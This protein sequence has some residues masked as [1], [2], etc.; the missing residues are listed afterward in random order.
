MIAKTKFVALGPLL[1]L[2]LVAGCS[3]PIETRIHSIGEG[4]PR[5]AAIGLPLATPGQFS[6]EWTVAR[7]SVIAALRAAGHDVATDSTVVVDVAVST[8]PADTA[9]GPAPGGLA[10]AAKRPRLLQSCHDQVQR[11]VVT[12]ID[13]SSGRLFY[14]GS[15]EEYHCKAELSRTLPLLAAR[16]LA[17]VGSPG[18]SRTERRAGID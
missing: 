15:A 4:L 12:I 1:A 2:M 7:D 16:A 6:P 17:D 5:G 11:L 8:R 10:S 14:R 9:I 13:R 18:G 3:G